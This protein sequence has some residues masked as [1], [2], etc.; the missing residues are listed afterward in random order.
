MTK[1]TDALL[2]NM[3]AMGACYSSDP[4]GTVRFP[5]DLTT[6]ELV[7]EVWEWWLHWDPVRMARSPRYSDALKSLRAVYVDAGRHDE[8]YLD[9]CA[10]A[11]VKALRDLGLDHQFE[12]FDGGHGGIEYRYPRAIRYLAANI[13]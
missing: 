9:L 8:Y 7:P 3:Y 13:R 10:E 11:F 1:P 2:L 12:L 6:G 5:F 4:D